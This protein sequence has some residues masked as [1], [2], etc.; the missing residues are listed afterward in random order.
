MSDDILDA[1]IAELELRLKRLKKERARLRIS[2]ARK[3]RKHSAETRAKMSAVRKVVWADPA[4]RAKI[5]A[6]VKAAWADPAVRAKIS[7]ARKAAAAIK[8]AREG[9]APRRIRLQGATLDHPPDALELA[10]FGR[11]RK[12]A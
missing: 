9:A 12:R 5:S 3:G 10:L 11:P 4:V 2:A 7:A 1:E 8:E 6:A